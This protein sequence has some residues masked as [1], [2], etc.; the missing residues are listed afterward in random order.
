MLY[1]QKHGVPYRAPG[2][3]ATNARYE[4]TRRDKRKRA[5]RLKQA[6][7][8]VVI[9]AGA[10]IDAQVYKQIQ[11]EAQDKVEY[12]AAMVRYRARADR[13]DAGRQMRGLNS[14]EP[15]APPRPR[16]PATGF[17]LTPRRF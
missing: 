6:E 16:G 3:T 14:L 15:P 4:R 8:D 2:R 1:E 9:V 5:R 10:V 11:L 13:E 12:E 17:I 7:K